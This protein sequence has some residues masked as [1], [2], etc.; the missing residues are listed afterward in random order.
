MGPEKKAIRFPIGLLKETL[1][2]PGDRDVLSGLVAFS[3]DSGDYAAALTYAEQLAQLMPGDG[4][5]ARPIG[6]LRRQVGKPGDW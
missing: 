2:H 1:A 6:A 4:S 5:V 3:R